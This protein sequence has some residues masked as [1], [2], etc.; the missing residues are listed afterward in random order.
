LL[1]AVV[2]AAVL[3]SG[4]VRAQ[5]DV[6]E[7]TVKLESAAGA[8]RVEVLNDLARATYGN[9]PQ[10]GLD[11]SGQAL[12]LAR[13]IGDAEGEINALNNIGICHYFLAEYD[14]ALD[15]YSRSLALAEAAGDDEGIANAL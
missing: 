12:D 15:Y 10:K 2:F 11:Y 6:D 8:E 4:V 7:L 13:R 5:G 1:T 14:Q 9:S 3:A